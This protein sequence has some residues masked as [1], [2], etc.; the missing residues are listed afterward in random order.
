MIT[1]N[2]V[3]QFT[4]GEYAIKRFMYGVCYENAKSALGE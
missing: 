4:G 1:V 2:Q 3:A